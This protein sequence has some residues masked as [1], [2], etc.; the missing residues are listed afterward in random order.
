MKVLLV[1]CFYI[2]VGGRNNSSIGVYKCTYMAVVILT[3]ILQESQGQ[4]PILRISYG[5]AFYP[6]GEVNVDEAAWGNSFIIPF[7]DATEFHTRCELS[8]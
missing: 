2:L 3:L 4:E 7:I 8:R 5:V 1:L 6:F